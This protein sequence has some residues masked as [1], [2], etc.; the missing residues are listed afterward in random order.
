M[1]ELAP[2]DR[3]ELAEKTRRLGIPAPPD[4]AGE[5]PDALVDG[6]DELIERTCFTDDGAKLMGGR[7]QG[8]D[9]VARECAR[10]DRLDDQDALD[11]ALIDQGDAEE[12]VE[13]IFTG[14]AEVFE[15]RM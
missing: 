7:G 12:G 10:L 9:L 1:R 5:G 2:A 13:G 11:H 4:V 14:L 8:A 3:V 6:G 15:A